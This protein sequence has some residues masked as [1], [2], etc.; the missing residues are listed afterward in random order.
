LAHD[1]SRWWKLAAQWASRFGK[2]EPHTYQ[3]EAG[4]NKKINTNRNDF[5]SE[6]PPLRLIIS[7]GLIS[8]LCVYC[9]DN[10]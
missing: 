1:Y 6:E 7:T 3:E 2:K 4:G 5:L 10:V 8:F 9:F